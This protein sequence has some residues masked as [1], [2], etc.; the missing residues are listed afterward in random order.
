L[1][2]E[3]SSS[4]PHIELKVIFAELPS[5]EA[6]SFLFESELGKSIPP[7]GANGLSSAFLR[8][9]VE[10]WR[11][12]PTTCLVEESTTVARGGIMAQIQTTNSRHVFLPVGS[13]A[14]SAV[15]LDDFS[16]SR[17][18]EP[19]P[20]GPIVE[21]CPETADGRMIRLTATSTVTE[22]LW[23]DDPGAFVVIDSPVLQHAPSVAGSLPSNFPQRGGSLNSGVSRSAAQL[24]RPH[25][26][27]RQTSVVC[28]AKEGDAVL[29]G[30]IP[31]EQTI[32]PRVNS[33]P[34]LGDLARLKFHSRSRVIERTLLIFVSPS[35]VAE[36]H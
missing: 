21:I 14:A 5:D 28:L 16:G 2:P 22:G 33:G 1:V 23:Y 9:H 10:K 13:P 17:R 18:V 20:T 19:Q 31:L 8:K 15:L 7:D 29:L 12:A 34:V 4:S 11:A 24:P 25:Y 30:T 36:S 6:S 27:V 32:L 35:M 3:K 26:R